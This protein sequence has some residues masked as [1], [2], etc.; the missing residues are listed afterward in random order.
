ME[1]AATEIATFRKRI[2]KECLICFDVNSTLK[3]ILSII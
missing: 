1:P 3:E 2:P